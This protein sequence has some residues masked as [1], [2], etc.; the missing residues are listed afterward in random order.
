VRKG[1]FRHP[2]PTRVATRFFL[3]S[4]RRRADAHGKFPN[5]IRVVNLPFHLFRLQSASAQ[6]DSETIHVVTRTDVQWGGPIF[7]AP[8][9]PTPQQL[10]RELPFFVNFRSNARA[11]R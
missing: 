9:L 1:D 10:S 2:A 5:P 6:R 4:R 3:N 7:R 11:R 8:A